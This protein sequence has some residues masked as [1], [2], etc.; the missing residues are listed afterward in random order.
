MQRIEALDRAFAQKDLN[1]VM[2]LYSPDYQD[3][4]GWQ[5]QYVRRAF[6]WFFQHYRACVMHRQI[7]QW[8]FSAYDTSGPEAADAATGPIAVLLYCRFSGY[9]LSDPTG[10]MADLPAY[11]PRTNTSEVWF[12]FAEREG[13]WR[14]VRTDPALPNFKDI[15]SFS[16]SPYDALPLGPDS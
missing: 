9:A 13:V 4:Q 1:G 7:R 15:L 10:R 3:P 11:F 6:E 5:I 8:D 12:Y 14:I 2:D 16:A